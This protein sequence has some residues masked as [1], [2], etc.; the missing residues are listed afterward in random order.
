MTEPGR[1]PPAIGVPAWP[2]DT[3]FYQVFPDR[4]ARSGRV[5]AP[6]PLQPWDAPPT[7]RGFKGGDLYGI[8]DRLDD[9]ADLGIGGLY[10]NPIFTATS[11]HRY[12]TVDYFEVDPLL[13]G[14]AALRTLIDE[15]HSTFIYGEH[16]RGVAEHFGLE[17]EID[18]HVGTLSKDGSGYAF[19]AVKA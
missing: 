16:G 10:L 14:S 3:V 13:G 8:V 5:P 19:E 9:L 15:A 18:I 6:G 17:D 2:A 11:N 12:N 4:F 1:L 7:Q